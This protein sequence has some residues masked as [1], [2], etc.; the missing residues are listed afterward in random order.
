MNYNNNGNVP[1]KASRI[2]V[3]NLS[4]LF[5]LL[6]GA[7]WLTITLSF[8]SGEKEVQGRSLFQRTN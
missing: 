4:S 3:E 2:S 6:S 5:S 8:H 1:Q 7:W